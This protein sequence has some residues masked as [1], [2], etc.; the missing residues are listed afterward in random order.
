MGSFGDAEIAH[1]QK[2]EQFRAER[3]LSAAW[4]LRENKWIKRLA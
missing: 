4:K 3:T 2:A 1:E